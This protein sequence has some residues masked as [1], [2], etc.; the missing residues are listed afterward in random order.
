[1]LLEY[2]K[3]AM[4]RAKYEILPDDGSYYGETPGLD[5]VFANAPTLEG[6]RDQLAEVLEDWILIGVAERH[7][8]PV[9]DGITITVKQ[10]T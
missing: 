5:G 7:P 6:C 4:R 8:L 10:T 2:M 3:A 1:M 9:I